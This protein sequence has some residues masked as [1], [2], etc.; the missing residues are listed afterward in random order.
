MLEIIL[1]LLWV[2]VAAVALAL[3]VHR[4]LSERERRRGWVLVVA[5]ACAMLLLLPIISITD[6]L[7]AAATL[8]ERTTS[9]RRPASHAAFHGMIAILPNIPAN[10]SCSLMLLGHRV[11]PNF[12]V[13]S[14]G[15]REA[16]IVRGPPQN[17]Y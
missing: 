6:D 4:L 11:D 7:S 15:T 12:T 2:C 16:E 3:T 5:V 1:N 8:V 14:P 10:A 13:P 17:G 9:E